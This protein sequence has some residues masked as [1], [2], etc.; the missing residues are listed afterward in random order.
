MA[1]KVGAAATVDSD[2]LLWHATP[3]DTAGNQ[4]SQ[5]GSKKMKKTGLTA[6]TVLKAQYRSTAGTGQ[7]LERWMAVKPIKVT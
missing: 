7:F 6:S 1:L 2:R 5:T 3:A 4:K